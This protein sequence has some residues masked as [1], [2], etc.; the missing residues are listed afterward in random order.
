M[1]RRHD[2]NGNEDAL[3]S[4]FEQIR[5]TPLLSFEEECEYSR[6]IQQGDETARHKLIVANLRLVVKIAKTFVSSDVG[7]LD[8]IQEGNL[9][10]MKAAEK[11]DY[12]KNVRFSTY[13]SWWI[14][15]SITRAL[16][17]KRRAIRLPHRKEEALKK[18]QRMYNILSQRL[19]RKPSVEEIASELRMRPCEVASILN[20][21]SGLVSLDCELG[22][23]SG[24]LFDL[25]E[26]TSYSPEKEFFRD[27][28]REETMQFLEKLMDKERQILLYRFSFY[29]GK[30]YTLKRIGDELGISAETVRQIE[31]RAL[32]KLR[33][34][35][36]DLR[37]YAAN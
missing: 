1:K 11:Y 35:A 31:L 30:K 9:G 8:L 16:A 23:E 33:E 21:A 7:L 2:M 19:M 36:E 34:Q 10:L 26:D 3:R 20:I 6:R 18:I 4:Y 28:L 12:R 14:K 13:A 5:K 22:P 37:M 25:Y 27:E 32:K 29:G 17:N 15:Q 24:S